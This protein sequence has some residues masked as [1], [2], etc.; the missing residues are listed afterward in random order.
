MKTSRDRSKGRALALLA[1]GLMALSSTAFAEEESGS[2]SF[3]DKT[4]VTGNFATS[5][6]FN[7][8]NPACPAAGCP[9]L[10]TLR[11]FD[12]RHNN[13]DFN[14]A[15]IAIENAPADWVKFRLDL[16][17]GEDVAAVD[18]LKGGVIGVDEFGV[19]Q[20]YADLTANV[21][22]GIT[23]RAGHFVTPIGYEVIES[24][25]NLNT[26]RSL[27]FGFAIPF[28]H[29]GVTMTYP[30]SDKFTGMVG[31]VNGWDL[32]GDN[33]KGK[34]IL[35]Q[36][37]YKPIDTL[38]LSLQGTFGPEQPGSDGNLRGLVDFVG[39]WTPNDKWI[40]GLNFD[41]GKEEGIG[42][43]GFANWWGGAGYVHW[44]PLDSFG[45]TLRGELMQDDGSRLLIGTN[46]TVGEGTLTA[47]FYLGDGWETRIEARHD[48]AD[49][50]IYLRSNGTT[51]KFQDTVSAEVVY[52]F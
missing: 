33:N 47:H 12:T 38:L 22:N 10:N 36:L 40:V 37:V 30:F 28:T 45:L 20:A 43:S 9:G 51:R 18:V 29:T 27:L 31:V 46:G 17:Y 52:A 26:S 3:W 49:R 21:G 11:V 16:N 8:N 42:G 23:F 4:K 41:L 32:I 13:F 24:A 25:Y 44:K 39:T 35:A 34:S 7:F 15:E 48:Q 2:A 6:N 50:G 19:Q 1:A 14:L 5:Y